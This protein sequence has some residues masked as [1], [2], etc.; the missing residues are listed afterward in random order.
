MHDETIKKRETASELE[1]PNWAVAT[2]TGVIETGLSYNQAV[3]TVNRNLD[4]PGICIITAEAA[5]RQEELKN[6]RNRTDQ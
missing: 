2:T 3:G 6:G 5:A 4:K 1:E